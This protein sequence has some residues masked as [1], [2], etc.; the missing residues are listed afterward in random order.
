[1]TGSINDDANSVG[2]SIDVETASTAG[3]A[4]ADPPAATFN[5]S[6]IDA[7]SSPADGV[8]FVAAIGVAAVDRVLYA[9]AHMP[10][11]VFTDVAIVH[12]AGSE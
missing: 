8:M 4:V 6:E 9:P 1:M 11:V 12:P 5:T 10:H 2:P 3:V 7:Y